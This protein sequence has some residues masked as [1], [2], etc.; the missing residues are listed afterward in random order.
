MARITIKEAVAITPVSEST[1]RRDIKTTKLSSEK[2]SRGRRLIDTAELARV[3]GM[4]TQPTQSN[5]SEMTAVD[6]P[7]NATDTLDTPS[8]DPKIIAL[9]ETQIDDLKAQLESANAE[10]KELLELANRLQKQNEV[11]MLPSDASESKPNWLL[12]LV[13]VR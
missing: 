13:G 1:I 10:K 6:T 4:L 8:D 11:L 3:Y 7:E 12:R 2:D 5:D 9:L